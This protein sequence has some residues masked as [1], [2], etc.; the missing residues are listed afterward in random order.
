MRVPVTEPS[1]SAK[2]TCGSMNW[3]AVSCGRRRKR[4]S[5]ESAASRQQGFG[6]SDDDHLDVSFLQMCKYDAP[7]STCAACEASGLTTNTFRTA[8][9]GGGGGTDIARPIHQPRAGHG[10]WWGFTVAVSRHGMPPY[11]ER[12]D[13]TTAVTCSHRIFRAKKKK[14]SG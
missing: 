13:N 1:Q 8:G 14:E 3:R 6:K 7:A 4:V 2:D 10:D 12:L 9:K 11:A 5:C